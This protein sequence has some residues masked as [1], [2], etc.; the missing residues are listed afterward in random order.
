MLTLTI[1]WRDL[2]MPAGC[3]RNNGPQR[4]MSSAQYNDTVARCH[5]AAIEKIRSGDTS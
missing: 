4:M 1:V 5:D 2:S 3:D